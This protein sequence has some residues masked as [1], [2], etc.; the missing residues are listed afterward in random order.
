MA[1]SSRIWW[2]SAVAKRGGAHHGFVDQPREAVQEADALVGEVMKRLAET[3][4]GERSAIERQWEGVE[5]VSTEDLRI[6]LKRYRSFFERL[7][8]V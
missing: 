8:S 4:T 3:F 1:R 6:A 7:L 2:K 5:Q